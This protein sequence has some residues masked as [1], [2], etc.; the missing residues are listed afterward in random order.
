MPRVDLFMPETLDSNTKPSPVARFRRWLFSWRT[1]RRTLV[2][3]AALLTLLALLITEENWRGKRAWDHYRQEWA[4]KGERFDLASVVPPPV[5]DEQNFF[6]APIVSRV[7]GST[8]AEDQ[9][10]FRI[11]RGDSEKWPTKGGSWRQATLT[12]LKPWQQYIRDLA[13]STNTFPVAP[14]P[15]TPAADVLLA[16]GQFN[17]ALEELR[18]AGQRPEARL[19]LQY[20]N[21]FEGVGELLPY[22]ASLKRCGQL[23]ELRALAGLDHGQSDQ[24]LADVKLLLRVTD[25]LRNQPFLI[26]HLVRM[27]MM[28]LTLQPIYEGLAQHRW[29]EPQLAELERELAKLDFLADYQFAMRGE[30]TCAI[31]AF[32]AQR[33][34]REYR[35]VEESFGTNKVVTVSFR[36]MPSAFFYQNELAFARL[37]EQFILPLVDLTNRVV[38]PALAQAAAAAVKAQGQT[39]S[40]Y[41][42]QALM[43]FPAI[44]KAVQKFAFAQS[45]IDLVRVAC[46]LERYRLA[47]GSYPESLNA[48]V[49]QFI[50]RLPHDII[51]GQPLNYRRTAEGAFVLYAVGWNETDDGGV[52]AL[53]K[54]K[55]PLVDQGDWVWTYPAK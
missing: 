35:T 46:A 42:V 15:Q 38:S 4:A 9:G 18:Q 55:S 39:Y 37:H 20:E 52:V 22:L 17:P 31:A 30:R 6:A 34:T 5:P 32:E 27:A 13:G 44:S 23:L 47:Q 3:L 10:E 51:N 25:S 19:P 12:D 45:S 29:S 1:L 40:P 53:S 50:A 36:F 26:S 48:L 54:G 14:Q 24:A 11:Y 33:I 43:V 16:L 7:L 28:A 21:G 41:Q 49:P 2:A 8:N